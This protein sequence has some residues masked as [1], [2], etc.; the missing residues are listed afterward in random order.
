MTD[1]QSTLAPRDSL[2][3]P[4]LIARVRTGDTAAYETLFLR[5]REVARRFALRLAGKERADDICSESFA[6]ILDLLQRGKGPDVAFRAYLLT[7]VRTVHLNQIRAGGRESPVA[8]TDLQ[9]LTEAVGD[10]AD[11]RFDEG[12]IARAFRQLP[13][14]W[15]S[16]LWLSAVEG[17]PNEEISRQLGIQSSAVASLAFR[18]RAGLRQAYLAEHLR[19]TVDAECARIV[20][21]LPG[22]LRGSLSERR[23]QL[24]A[25]HL[26]R[27]SRC[28]V[29]AAELADVDRRLGALLAPLIV[30]GAATALWPA[31]AA[32]PTA[33]VASGVLAGVGNAGG[34]TILGGITGT[35]GVAKAAT[36]A[37][38][39]AASIGLSVN[40]VT[41]GPHD[42]GAAPRSLHS[43]ADDS[44][45]GPFALGDPFPG[46]S[47]APPGPTALLTATP[48]AIPTSAAPT[49]TD[50]HSDPAAP[51]PTVAGPTD[52][53]PTGPTTSPTPTSS[54]ERTMA[55]GSME[56]DPFHRNLMQ[57]NRVTAPVSEPPEGTRLIL[58]SNHT[59]DVRLATDET[60][61]WTCAKPVLDWAAWN[62][63][64]SSTVCTFRGGGD[65]SAVRVEYMVDRKSRLTATLT[66]PE[67]YLDLDLTDNIAS[68]DLLD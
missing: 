58:T 19:E 22:F 14:R 31:T 41:S 53:G 30:G 52:G 59:Y 10:D 26:E 40:A 35:I 20:D 34:G 47:P 17:V 3:D 66:A 4:E 12:A 55:M 37:T 68:I 57:W 32:V 7:T 16:A 50:G 36:A 9:S 63:P 51:D 33:P 13:E 21:L 64:R 15:Q 39:A 48:S 2:S 56:N 60:S 28:T 65:G 11:A 27:C 8:D 46:R 18:A 6:K 25:A 54:G 29:A 23:R 49:P 44:A 1:D 42:T 24:V 62:G 45:E 38:I 67:G 43:P 61:G 5:H